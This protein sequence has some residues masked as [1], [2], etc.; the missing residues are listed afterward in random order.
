MVNTEP[1]I[2]PLLPILSVRQPWAWLLVTGLKDIE[3]RD[4]LLHHRGRL[5]IHASRSVDDFRSD[6]F[7]IKE[8]FKVVVPARDQ[9]TFGAVIGSVEVVDCVDDHASRWFEGPHGLVCV[10]ARVYE[11]PVEATGRLGLFTL[12][13]LNEHI[14]A[15]E[16]TARAFGASGADPG[17]MRR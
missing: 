7:W 8:E 10:D 14:M 2:V 9:L 16:I 6:C 12:P 1:R 15:Q 13:D 11:F 5:G 4:Y 17:V 3:N